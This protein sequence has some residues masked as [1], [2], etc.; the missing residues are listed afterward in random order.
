M[1]SATRP[2]QAAAVAP[3]DTDDNDDLSSDDEDLGSMLD[4]EH[5]DDGA[6]TWHSARQTASAGGFAFEG[7]ATLTRAAAVPAGADLE[8]HRRAAMVDAMRTPLGTAGLDVGPLLA[9]PLRALP[10]KPISAAGAAASVAAAVPV[11]RLASSDPGGPRRDN[12]AS[13]SA[14]W[15]QSRAWGELSGQQRQMG[16]VPSPGMLAAARASAAAASAVASLSALVPLSEQYVEGQEPVLSPPSGLM[17]TLGQY[18]ERYIWTTGAQTEPERR[19]VASQITALADTG[20]SPISSPRIPRAPS[21]GPREEPQAPEVFRVDIPLKGSAD[22][23]DAVSQSDDDV[24]HSASDPSA[25]Y[26]RGVVLASTVTF[27][28]ITTVEL[29]PSS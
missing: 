25:Q 21:L 6:S 14:G 11:S 17:T 9:K 16:E 28:H 22:L 2:L 3:T 1:L 15:V 20:T 4:G 7:R 24:A 5:V 8:E 13:A 12:G 27:I 19:D 29:F 23:S 18:P 26:I 10:A